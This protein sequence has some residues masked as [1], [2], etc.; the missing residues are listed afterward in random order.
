MNNL[1]LWK[2]C[3]RMMIVNKQ[4]RELKFQSE[5]C[6][7][8]CISKFIIIIIIIIITIIVTTIVIIIIIMILDGRVN[9][10]GRFL[11]KSE[12]D[13]MRLF[14]LSFNI[15]AKTCIERPFKGDTK[16]SLSVC[17]SPTH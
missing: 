4:P 5:I 6:F 3:Q 17:L 10:R 7:C 2:V 9:G 15:K 12:W 8:T 16:G 11:E 1:I 14:Q 13:E